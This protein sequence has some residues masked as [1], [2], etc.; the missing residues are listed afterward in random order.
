MKLKYKITGMLC[1]ILFSTLAG[2]LGYYTI[3][4]KNKAPT[5][6]V[7]RYEIFYSSDPNNF[8]INSTKFQVRYGNIIDSSNENT[9]LI[10]TI[11]DIT[12]GIQNYARVSY[13]NPFMNKSF[14]GLNVHFNLTCVSTINF[15]FI[16]PGNTTLYYSQKITQ[17]LINYHS[18]L[19]IVIIAN[20]LIAEARLFN[21][22]EINVE[23]VTNLPTTIGV[24]LSA[25]APEKIDYHN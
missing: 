17:E 18:I 13:T 12:R 1:L 20:Q 24:G 8:T 21:V 10:S 4:Q 14:F 3:N 6:L 23:I 11:W 9:T 19:G 5:D 22:S 15:E 2:I 16:R 7:A 25:F